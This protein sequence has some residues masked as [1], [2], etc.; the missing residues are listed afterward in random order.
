MTARDDGFDDFLDAVEGG[1]PYYLASDDGD[2]YIPPMPHDPATGGD[3]NRQ[4]L[5]DA[6]EIL[7]HTTTHVATPEFVDDAPYVTAVVSFGPVHLTG[8]VRDLD[9][10]AVSIG[11]SV[12]LGIERTETTGA[13]ILVFYPV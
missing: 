1:D 10:E 3:L 7:T 9:P 11:Q 2:A 8:Q 4:S 12:E 5:P 6:G 13:R